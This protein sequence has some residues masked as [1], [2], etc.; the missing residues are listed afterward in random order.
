MVQSVLHVLL[1]CFTNP[2]DIVKRNPQILGSHVA[3]IMALFEL[4]MSGHHQE[5]CK[6]L[7]DLEVF[8][9]TFE[10]FSKMVTLELYS[11]DWTSLTLHHN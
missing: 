10:A 9:A 7:L 5:L 6:S 4:I 1:E 11:S 3:V 8:M 2:T